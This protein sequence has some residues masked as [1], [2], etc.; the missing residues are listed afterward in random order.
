[1]AVL[2]WCA[3]ALSECV[4]LSTIKNVYLEV[5]HYHEYWNFENCL[6]ILVLLLAQCFID[7]FKAF[8]F[9]RN[10]R[11]TASC[12]LVFVNSF[13]IH[14]DN[15]IY[16]IQNFK[17]N[18]IIVCYTSKKHNH[19]LFMINQLTIFLVALMYYSVTD[20]VPIILVTFSW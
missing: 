1:M 10:N 20:L 11:N 16:I 7:I 6:V 14:G 15:N 13:C 8:Q 2:T 5:C 12:P 19:I 17:D 4:Y 9:Y 18:I 3:L